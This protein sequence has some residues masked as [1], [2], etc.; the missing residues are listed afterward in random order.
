MS[1]PGLPSRGRS[2][3]SETILAR[4][5]GRAVDRPWQSEHKGSRQA[6]TSTQVLSPVGCFWRCESFVR[7]FFFL[8]GMVAPAIRGPRQA[9]GPLRWVGAPTR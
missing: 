3:S 4:H 2:L 7:A 1:D 5:S 6:M 8:R 9:A